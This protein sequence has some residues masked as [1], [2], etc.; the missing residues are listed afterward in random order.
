MVR[1][2]K[3]A[4]LALLRVAN[5]ADLPN[6]HLGAV[7]AVAELA[8][9]VVCGFPLGEALA[10]DKKEY[11]AVSVNAG[12]VTALH[13]KGGQLQFIQIDAALNVRNSGGPVLDDAGKVIGVVV[14]GRPGTGIN[15]AIP[16][17]ILERFLKAPD[18]GVHSAGVNPRISTSPWSSRQT[19][20]R[21]YPRPLNRL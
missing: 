13:L 4:D 7:D 16:V 18:L 8:E 2:D 14:S 5:V 1:I 19:S 11:P 15:Q 9:V 3:T 12:S 20:S 17:N 21:S 6:L 10:T